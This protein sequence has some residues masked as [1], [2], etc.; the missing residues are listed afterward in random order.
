MMFTSPRWTL[1]WF[2]SLFLIGLFLVFTSLA[3][4]YVS[5][6]SHRRAAFQ[7]DSLYGAIS[8]TQ[9]RRALLLIK[10]RPVRQP[11]CLCFS[12]RWLSM[13]FS[14]SHS[15]ANLFLWNCISVECPEQSFLCRNTIYIHVRQLPTCPASLLSTIH[16]CDVNKS[17]YH[18]MWLI[19]GHRPAV[20]CY[21]GDL[22]VGGSRSKLTVIRL[23]FAVASFQRVNPYWRD[24]Q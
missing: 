15:R 21:H 7:R 9:H 24:Q 14:I 20:S 10:C 6:P 12:M 5:P 23:H 22:S 4:Y 1:K 19:W 11:V 2:K 16:I 17:T 8:S 18:M 13:W 3:G